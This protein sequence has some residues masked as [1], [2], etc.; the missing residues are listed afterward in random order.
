MHKYFYL[1]LLLLSLV[2]AQC[3][4]AKKELKKEE[5]KTVVTLVKMDTF[6]QAIHSVEHFNAQGKITERLTFYEREI[7]K[8]RFEKYTYNALNQLVKL[9][10]K[11]PPLYNFEY[12][13]IKRYNN[14]GLLM[15][16]YVNDVYSEYNLD[17]YY[18]KS[19]KLMKI[20]GFNKKDD[21]SDWKQDLIYNSLDSLTRVETVYWKDKERN[22]RDSIVYGNN[23]KTIYSIDSENVQT[24]KYVVIYR[25]DKIVQEYNYSHNYLSD[26]NEFYLDEVKS[27]FYEG[28]LLVKKIVKHSPVNA[29][30]GTGNYG[31]T[32]TFTYFYE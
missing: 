30:C 10:W 17:Y 25:N 9:E 31:H 21:A 16:R 26:K 24:R 2:V 32:E 29:L 14:R 4:P 8:W 28:E 1:Y 15:K 13:S 18:D 7:I 19:N 3:T 23:R 5:Y 27:Y 20:V 12:K 6:P 22:S 11:F